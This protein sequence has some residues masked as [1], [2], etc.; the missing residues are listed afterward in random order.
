MLKNKIS[1]KSALDS[2][3]EFLQTGRFPHF[4]TIKRNETTMKIASLAIGNNTIEAYNSMWTGIETVYFN[5]IRVSK[6]FNWFVGIHEFQVMADDGVN[7]DYYRVDFRFSFNNMSC[8]T[9]DVFRNGECL[10]DQSGNNYRHAANALPVLPAN[11]GY[12]HRRER[13]AAPLYQEEDL[14]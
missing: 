10:F 7:T 1:S 13:V 4:G 12:H 14:V 5:G 9:V 8:I 11:S 3:N 6:Q 2:S